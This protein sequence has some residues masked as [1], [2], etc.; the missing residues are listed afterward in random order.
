M[1]TPFE[2]SR[3]CAKNLQRLCLLHMESKILG[4]LSFPLQT[5]TISVTFSYSRCAEGS[6]R[7]AP[8]AQVAGRRR[9]CVQ[10]CAATRLF[11]ARTAAEA[12]RIHEERCRSNGEHALLLEPYFSA[13]STHH[14]CPERHPLPSTIDL[15]MLDAASTHLI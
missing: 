7:Q 15:N 14:L 4:R 1:L 5:S 12:R 3:A 6:N 8:Q 2:Q 11:T 13:F 9:A 10:D